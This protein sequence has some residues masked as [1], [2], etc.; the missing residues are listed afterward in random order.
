M[1]TDFGVSRDCELVGM[2]SVTEI[3]SVL[4]RERGGWGW[5]CGWAEALEQLAEP[6]PPQTQNQR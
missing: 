6:L 3:G 5:G 1:V 2:E 4:W